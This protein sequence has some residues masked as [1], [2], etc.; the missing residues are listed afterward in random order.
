MRTIGVFRWFVSVSVLLWFLLCFTSVA[1][2]QT[3]GTFIAVGNMTTP[4][5]GH[6]AT[7]L[8]NGKVLITGGSKER[9]ASAELFDPVTNTFTRTGNITT[10]RLFGHTATLLPDGRVLIVGGYYFGYLDSA[11][12]YDPLTGTFRP[13]GNMLA[14][15]HWGQRAVLL[16]NG[17]VLIAG[18]GADCSNGRDGCRIADFP[19]VYDPDTGTFSIAGDYADRSD[20][21]WFATH[22]LVGAP[23]TLLPNDN[24]LIAAEPITELYDPS[25][26]ALRLTGQMTRGRQY[27]V[28]AYQIGG[29][30]TLL[31]NGKVLL[32]GGEIFEYQTL[33]DAE[34]YNPATGT[35]SAIGNMSRPRIGHTATLLRDGTVFIAG[36]ASYSCEFVDG[37]GTCPASASTESYNPVTGTFTTSGTMITGRWYHTATLL[38]D[39]R[40]LIAG[41]YPDA[42]FVPMGGAEVYVPSVLIPNPV[43]RSFEFDPAVVAPG[44]SYS[45]EVSGSDLTAQMF[46]DVRFVNPGSDDSLSF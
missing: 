31:T 33:A 15:Q 16:N 44:F 29:T 37:H 41:G 45:V 18:G 17:K 43:V 23:L 26:K 42:G 38:M 30:A 46:F 22:G 14:P 35:F 10:G 32:A 24:V 28:P 19:E 1:H 3:S 13:T 7:L 4:R 2:A 6:T 11:E 27:G 21:P 39:G 5:T 20:D 40:I 12:I 9:P 34:L 25:T 36:S 8:L